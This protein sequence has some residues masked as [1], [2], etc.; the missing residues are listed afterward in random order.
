VSFNWFEVNTGTPYS[1][2]FYDNLLCESIL[3][4]NPVLGS[5]ARYFSIVFTKEINESSR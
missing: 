3:N 1:V 5:N 4:L 2:E